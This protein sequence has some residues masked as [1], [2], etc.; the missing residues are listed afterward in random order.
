MSISLLA[1]VIVMALSQTF[2]LVYYSLRDHRFSLHYLFSTGGMPSAHSAFVTTVTLSVGLWHG[3]GTE[4]FAVATV[5]SCI[6]IYDSA[7]LRGAVDRHTQALRRLHIE[8][9][10]LAAGRSRTI[11]QSA[12]KKPASVSVEAGD[13]RSADV[14][15]R[16]T[17]LVTLPRR[18]GHTPVE[19]LVGI[20]VGAFF[21]VAIY[22]LFAGQRS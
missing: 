9:E 15:V 4:L 13:E 17:M 16:E 11:G 3:F 19:V 22:L 5:F 8:L 14:T 10:A 20:A 6:I 2:K 7:R 12:G 1:A 21:A 18:V